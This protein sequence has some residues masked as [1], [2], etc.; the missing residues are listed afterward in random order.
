MNNKGLIRISIVGGVF[1]GIIVFIALYLAQTP[2]LQS[3][4]AALAALFLCNVF[5]YL[6]LKIWIF[7][8]LDK[9]YS[10]F[11]L[12]RAKNNAGNTVLPTP[13]NDPIDNLKNELD[14]WIRFKKQ[15]M[16]E[17]K[18]SDVFRKDFIG[19]VSHEL[20]TPI[21]NI[22]GYLHT[23]I[24]NDTEE[25]ELQK[26]FLGKAAKNADRLSELVEE[27][28]SL[29]RME[30]GNLELK[31]QCFDIHTLILELFDTMEF[32]A[33]EKKI[34]LDFK[35]GSDKSFIVEADKEG[36]GQVL[37]NLLSNS[38]NYGVEGGQTLVNFQK[39]NNIILIEVID[40]GVG[41]EPQFISRIFE[42]F[43]RVDRSRSRASGGTGLGLAIVKHILESHNQQIFVESIPG[44]GS[45]FSFTLN[46]G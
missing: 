37:S 23:V 7:D 29:S 14:H 36:I 16:E 26:Y 28:I 13:S 2:V 22:Q 15:E 27:L 34:E 12:L 10:Y 24:D 46:K 40:N 33:S 31:M 20:K 5:L 30:S 3:A 35:S 42:R 19:N 21:F 41:I 17:L 4:L 43:Y 38:I 11:Q 39:Q 9:L 1:S 32:M 25:E 45:K 6:I 44:N 18:K 8:R